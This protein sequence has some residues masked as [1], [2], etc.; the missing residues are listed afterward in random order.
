MLLYTGGRLPAEQ[1]LTAREA[2]R[3][4]ELLLAGRPGLRRPVRRRH[5]GRHRDACSAAR[6]RGRR[7]RSAAGCAAPGVTPLPAPPRAPGARTHYAFDSHG[8][9]GT[10]RVIVIDNSRG[11]L[12]ASDPHQN[13]PEPQ[14]PWLTRDARTTRAAEAIPA[15]VVGSRDLNSRFQPSLNVATD[16]D[17]VAQLLVDDGASAYFFERPEENRVYPIPSGARAHDPGVR[18]GHARLPLA[19]GEHARTG[20]DAVFG[21]AGLL[22]AEV[23]TAKRDP[24]TNRA[25][26]AVR[27]LP[28]GRRAD[29][30]GGRRHAPAPLAPV[31]VPGARPPAARRRPLGPAVGGGDPQPPGSDPY[32]TLPAQPC[33]GAG[34]RDPDR[35]RVRVHLLG[36]RHRRLRRAGPGV[37]EPAQ[38]ADRRRRQGRHRPPLRPV[39]PVQRGQD[40]DHGQGGRARLRDRDHRAGGLGSAPVRHAPARPGAL[41]P[42]AAGA[43]PRRRRRPRRPRRPRRRRRPAAAAAAAARRARASAS[44]ASRA[45]R[46][47]PPIA[48]LPPRRGAAAGRSAAPRAGS[49]PATP[50]PP[51]GAFARPIPPGGAVDPRVRGEARGGGRAR[52]VLGRRRLPLR[53]ARADVGAYLYGLVVL[54]AFAGATLRLGLRRRERGIAAAAVHVPSTLPLPEPPPMRR[55]HAALVVALLALVLSLHRRRR[56]RA[57]GRVQGR[58]QA[59]AERRPEARPQGQVPGQG[60]PEGRARARAPTGSAGRR[61]ADAHADLRPADRRPRHLVPAGRAVPAAQRGHRQERLRSTRRR[62]CVEAGGFLPTAA[63]LIGA[64]DRVKLASTIDD[65]PVTSSPDVDADGRAKDRR[66]MS[67]TLV[68]DAGRLVAPRARRASPRARAATRRRASRTRCRCRRTRPRSRCST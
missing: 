66:E 12:A 40:D 32:T 48:P 39:L 3:F 28:V 63:Q 68:T 20:P 30:A 62:T 34:V 37:D 26:V 11:S 55:Q 5:G 19:A 17:E 4:A 49:P 25:P 6:S 22:L 52:A 54:A 13:P 57:P 33:A 27:L 9:G 38:A 10:V 60:D 47:C 53:G 43:A 35:A 8:S 2:A 23:D 21:D 31:A 51:A 42:A 67:S 15:I 36:A 16:A 24:A 65:A 64:A 41:P 7:R 45:A 46:R 61:A 56:R 50:P 1:T 29:A 58:L 44:A 59:A 18:H 14:L